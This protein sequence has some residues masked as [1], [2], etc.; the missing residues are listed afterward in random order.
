MAMTAGWQLPIAGTP[1]AWYAALEG[2]AIPPL[3]TTVWVALTC[4]V[5][6][7]QLFSYLAWFKIVEIFPTQIAALATL[8]TP[9][10]GVLSSAVLLG[11]ALGW[12]ELVAM[13]LCGSA[14]ALVLFARERRVEDAPADPLAERQAS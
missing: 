14:L 6:L 12:P 2:F 13:A 7:S 10:I 11:E 3:S 5:I 8:L 1:S 9:L 4:T